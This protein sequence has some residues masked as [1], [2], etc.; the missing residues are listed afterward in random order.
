[1]SKQAY[2]SSNIE[3]ICAAVDEQPASVT[4]PL[5]M[6]IVPATVFE[7]ESLDMLAS[8]SAGA[9]EGF[10]YAR[11]GHPNQTV[12]ERLLARL[13]GAEAALACASGMGAISA[14]VMTGLRT[15]DRIVADEAL[16]GRTAALIAGPLAALGI[17]PVFADLSDMS[18][19]EQ[20]LAEPAAAVIVE[21]ISN[22]L[23]VIPDISGLATLAH[24]AGARLIVDNTLATPYHCRPLAHGAD[25][26][27]HSGSKYLGGHSDA[28]SGVLAG[29]AQIV[30]QAR[31]MMITLGSPAAPFDCWLTARGMKTL[32]LRMAAASANAERI[33]DFL[34]G[35]EGIIRD[36]R[37]PGLPS[38]PQ[39]ERARDQLERGFGAIVTFEVSGGRSAAA[40][41]IRGL[42]HIRLAPSFGDI[43]T[44]IASP[45]AVPEKPT[46]GACPKML[47]P[48]QLRLSAGVEHADDIMLDLKRGLALAAQQEGK[49]TCE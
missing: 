44:T 10:L 15:G 47:P 5:A 42:R 19:A 45:A 33:S 1:M 4:D 28:I 32:A 14:A 40:R 48:G 35:C 49:P 43:S 29:T 3:T 24:R 20:A 13:E 11:G 41:F 17:R 7:I 2:Q 26:V 30:R 6:P 23:L 21:S 39:H 22:P 25:L 36:V 38:H 18:A 9:A 16:Y 8:V 31:D 12:L 37:Y 27:V 46:D 34:S